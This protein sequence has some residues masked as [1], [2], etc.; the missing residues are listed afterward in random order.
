MKNLKTFSQ[1]V[2]EMHDST[3]HLTDEELES[4]NESTSLNTIG[5]SQK[6]IKSLLGKYSGAIQSHKVEFIPFSG[7]KKD[8]KNEMEKGNSIIAKKD[9]DNFIIVAKDRQWSPKPFYRVTI[10][11]NSSVEYDQRVPMTKALG[12]LTKDYREYYTF[13]NTDNLDPSKKKKELGR[14]SNETSDYYFISELAK[15]KY[16]QSYLVKILEEQLK[17]LRSMVSSWIKQYD[18]TN[19]FA[20]NTPIGP[21]NWDTTTIY[22]IGEMAELIKAIK[23]DGEFA[24]KTGENLVK[25]L[26]DRFID[27]SEYNKV[28]GREQEKQAAKKALAELGKKIHWATIAKG[29][30]M[31]GGIFADDKQLKE[32]LN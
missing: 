26:L 16:V 28:D 25:E 8:V 6:A 18:G 22:R 1:Y 12:F 5:I 32:D 27:E 4:M 10:I 24:G 11:T 29:Y 9:A 17:E 15:E 21:T 2:N 14:G 20:V 7:T 13:D 31:Y 30:G 3:L 19:K 23:G